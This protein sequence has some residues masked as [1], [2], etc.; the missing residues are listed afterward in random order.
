MKRKFDYFIKECLMN[1]RMSQGLR[2]IIDCRENKI[3]KA[4]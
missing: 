2:F 3:K 4:L 1:K